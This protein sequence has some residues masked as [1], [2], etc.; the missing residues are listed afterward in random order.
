MNDPDKAPQPKAG[1][2]FMPIVEC[3]APASTTRPS[4]RPYSARSVVATSQPVLPAS[5]S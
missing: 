5:G 4:S 2:P 3:C 1:D